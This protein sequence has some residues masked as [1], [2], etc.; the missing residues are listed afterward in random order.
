MIHCVAAARMGHRPLPSMAPMMYAGC[1][2][3]CGP[4]S[5]FQPIAPS[6]PT[7]LLVV[8]PGPA[9]PPRLRPQTL[10][11]PA[12]SPQAEVPDP[13]SSE[14]P[15]VHSIDVTVSTHDV[16]TQTELGNS[17]PGGPLFTAT[18]GSPAILDEP[19][20]R[21]PTGRGRQLA[22]LRSLLPGP[23]VEPMGT[24]PEDDED[25]RFWSAFLNDT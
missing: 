23:S 19:P 12:L 9:V 5:A 18:L 8:T 1:G 7:S 13:P 15:S 6:I 17:E 11:P 4:S 22:L 21:R 14:A 16:G 24:T 25:I 2:T 10:S 20:P 3:F